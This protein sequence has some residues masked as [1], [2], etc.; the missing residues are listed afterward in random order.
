MVRIISSNSD[1]M[2]NIPIH[3]YQSENGYKGDI[4]TAA[5]YKTSTMINRK[6]FIGNIKIGKKTYPDRMIESPV[7]RYDTFP[8]D[9]LH[10]VDVAVSDGDAIVKLENIGDKLIQFKE[11]HAY[12]L[13]V[14]YEGI[15]LVHSWNGKGIKNPI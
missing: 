9:G 4:V 11:H 13:K 5:M 15:D 6:V 14:D 2:R 7:D 12:V 3:T 1:I 8:D 10:Y